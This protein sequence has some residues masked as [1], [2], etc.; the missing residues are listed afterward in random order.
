LLSKNFLNKLAYQLH[1]WG[2][3]EDDDILLGSL[4]D[5]KK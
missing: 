3:E 5:M 4:N 2:G 1:R